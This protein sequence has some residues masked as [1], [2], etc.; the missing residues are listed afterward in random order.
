MTGIRTGAFVGRDAELSVCR[1]VISQVIHG[2]GRALLIDG[3]PGIGKSAL[4]GMVLELARSCDCTV[5][6][7]RADDLTQQFPMR[8]MLDC[9]GGNPVTAIHEADPGEPHSELAAPPLDRVVAIVTSLC[10]QSPVVLAI[11]DLHWADDQSLL[12]WR[13]LSELAPDLP[14]VVIGTYCPVPHRPELITLKRELASARQPVT[15]LG[16]LATDEVINLVGILTGGE[17]SDRLR[18]LAERAGGNPLYVTELVDALVRGERVQVADGVADIVTGQ[19]PQV[20]A[21]V[22]TER[23][24]FLS[25]Q[26]NRMLRFAAL[27]GRHFTTA[28]VAAVADLTQ[29]QLA[30]ALAEAQAAR[31][32]AETDGHLSFRHLLIRQAMYDSVPSSLRV[33]LHRQAAR[34]LA[35]AGAADERVAEQLLA[36]TE[37]ATNPWVRGWLTGA[38]P[39]LVQRVPGM[40]AKLFRQAIA[41][42]GPEDPDRDRLERGLAYALLRL[43]RPHEAVDVAWPLLARSEDQSERARIIPTLGYALLGS[44]RD[45]EALKLIEDVLADSALSPA[46]RARLRA[47]I[48]FIY[49]LAGQPQNA[50]EAARQALAESED[51]YAVGNALHTLSLLRAQQSDNTGVC[52][53]AGQALSIL[54]DR[55]GAAD[56]RSALLLNR[57]MALQELGQMA[58]ADIDLRTG[59][60]LTNLENVPVQL[61]HSAAEY[62]L[63]VGR[64]NEALDQL[65]SISGTP[66][67][68]AYPV[69]GKDDPLRHGIGAL[70]AGHRDDR[71]VAAAYLSAART[72]SRSAFPGHAA[73]LILAEALA[74]ERDGRF[75]DALTLLRPALDA[76]DIA[77][78]RLRSLCLP[79][80][81]R[82]ALECGHADLARTAADVAEQA[83]SQ[84]PTAVK[85]ATAEH[86]QGL[87]TRNPGLLLA[88]AKTYR[89]V[90]VP[91]E[92][93]QA[94][95]DAAELLASSEQTSQ[96]RHALNEATEG[97][98]AL[99]AEWD[100]RR[101]DTRLRRYGIRRGRSRSPGSDSLTPTESKIAQLISLG[102]S[103][104][105]IARD[106]LLSPRT[107][108]THVS[109]ILRKINGRSRMDI[110]R[111]SIAAGDPRPGSG[112][113]VPGDLSG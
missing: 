58:A 29:E 6:Q 74:A 19:Q 15:S 14:L 46:R 89:D 41:D 99:G 13:R 36:T 28:E 49:A 62:Y 2:R 18:R 3:E 24:N 77:S 44:G 94:T 86:C 84:E 103:T 111:A 85:R 70:I 25:P 96:A 79:T 110:V 87:I 101:A 32:I 75:E 83:A 91:L 105:D 7:G 78:V 8:V 63:R 9:L 76:N 39:Q 68:I 42:I 26:S 21:S 51:V 88:A 47:V 43:N 107:V 22:I 12:A 38:G 66:V 54:P 56:L 33:A 45:H 10:T 100:I 81:V 61:A 17:P 102:W 50:D 104:P 37:L 16:P 27:L 95:E 112:A 48:A 113:A 109:H 1:E 93:A 11:D 108:Q 53:L 34:S 23:L 80:L 5:L 35:E 64:W 98:T 72:V 65:A 60:D 106:M 31:V 59:Q 4:L 57:M 90:G 55:P 40:A 69:P 20:L 73:Y 92:R 30:P 82:L 52:E 97:Y 71:A 67:L